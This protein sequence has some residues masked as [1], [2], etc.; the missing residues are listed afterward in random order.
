MFHGNVGHAGLASCKAVYPKK[1]KQQRKGVS[2]ITDGSQSHAV[3]ATREVEPSH[4]SQHSDKS[5]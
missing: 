1:E 5:G 2:H 3:K 4:T